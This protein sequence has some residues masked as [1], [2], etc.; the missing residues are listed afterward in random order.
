MAR[1][2]VPERLSGPET[3][4]WR[5]ERDPMLR[6]GFV[7]V[8]IFDRPPDM[9]RL[10]A[11]VEHATRV[12]PRLRQRVEE[13]PLPL[14]APAWSDD[15]ELDIDYHLRSVALSRPRNERHLFDLA[16]LWA[17]DAFD[18]RRPLWG[19]T[20]VEGLSRNRAALVTKLHHAVTDGMGALRLSAVLTDLE[21]DAPSEPQEPGPPASPGPAT[22]DGA[23]GHDR[24]SFGGPLEPLARQ[25]GRLPGALGNLTSI[26]NLAASRVAGMATDP[27]SIP[28]EAAD[29]LETARSLARQAV[30]T[31]GPRSPLWAHRR[32]SSRYFDHMTL[33]LDRVRASAK[34]LGG[35]VN[36]LSVTGVS[37][38]AAAYHRLR[39]SAVDELRISMPVSTR[40]GKDEAANAFTPARVLVPAGIEDPVERFTAVHERLSEAKA[41]R[42]LGLADLLADALTAVPTPL[43]ARMARQQ[44]GTV[45]LAASNVRGAPF[46]IFVAGAEVEANYP[47]GPT[48]GTAFNATVLSYRDQLDMGLNVDPAAVDD[49]PLLRTCIDDAF[50][51][52]F[53]AAGTP[54][55]GR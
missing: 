20:V 22:S 37:G 17:Q 14:A 7:N 42:A 29:A 18:A 12:L 33:D 27:G 26:A 6:S 43:M 13:P 50:L 15:P 23:S 25:L 53:Q 3:L 45:D 47:M 31:D 36:D 28:R 52:L 48:M 24:S 54:S 55:R 30:V 35:T 16:A 51:E 9:G 34:A 10:R 1:R 40:R 41:E 2:Q 32:S 38:G 44:V 19:I 4:M 8:T 21:R 46:D 39:G 11:R 49:P 5:M